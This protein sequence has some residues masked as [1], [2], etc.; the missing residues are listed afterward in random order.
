ML[1]F[2]NLTFLT[3]TFVLGMLIPIAYILKSIIKQKGE[4]YEI[5]SPLPK[6]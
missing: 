5:D 1:A 4:P 6:K 2:Q 3:I